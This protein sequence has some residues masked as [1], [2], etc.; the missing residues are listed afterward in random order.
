MGGLVFPAGRR[1]PEYRGLDAI[2]EYVNEDG[3]LGRRNCGQAAAATLLTARG[4]WPAGTMAVMERLERRFPPDNLG[5]RWGTSRRCLEHLARAYGV[6]LREIVGEE[7]LCQ[8]LD[9][10]NPVLLMLG[11]SPRT[12]CRVPL[13]GGH[14]TVAYGYDREHVYLTNWHGG[15]I[16]W[17]EFR[18]RWRS[19]LA[20]LIRMRLRGLAAA[21]T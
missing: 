6:P 19:W 1:G 13:P 8:E 11:V 3:A 17:P 20:L 10:R 16:A 5:G 15:K 2:F 21:R 14:W 12:F 4:V 9:R 7:A 18:R